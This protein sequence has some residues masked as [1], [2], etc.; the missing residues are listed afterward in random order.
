MSEPDPSLVRQRH[1]RE[2]IAVVASYLRLLADTARDGEL[3]ADHS[4]GIPGAD[5]VAA[6]DSGRHSGESGDSVLGLAHLSQLLERYELHIGGSSGPG[7]WAMPAVDLGYY[8]GAF[9]DLN[10]APRA[11]P[12][13]DAGQRAFVELVRD[14][15]IDPNL[16][17][18]ALE[19]VLP[20][21]LPPAYREQVDEADVWI[22]DDLRR[23]SDPAARS[24]PSVA[25]RSTRLREAGTQLAANLLIE[26]LVHVASGVEDQ[27]RDP[28][29][30]DAPT[31]TLRRQLADF[32]V[33]YRYVERWCKAVM[34]PVSQDAV[35][36]SFEAARAALTSRPGG[37]TDRVEGD[38]GTEATDVAT[39]RG[40]G[41]LPDQP[42]SV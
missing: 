10:G 24:D 21:H 30:G 14:R 8:I 18:A 31:H 38:S 34:S 15:R 2:G 19:L 33:H 22:Q 6:I 23:P 1:R 42:R 25:E 12:A 28:A 5:T 27:L 9:F 11:L 26:H 16:R 29:S 3:R 4:R 35:V 17:A 37:P 13:D 7:P 41:R 20:E 32:Y 36:R 39:R 40:V